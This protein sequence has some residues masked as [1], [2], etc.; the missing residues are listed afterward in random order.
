MA[1]KKNKK[2][3]K[4]KVLAIRYKIAQEN[5]TGSNHSC[6]SCGNSIVKTT[7]NKIFCSNGRTKGR[8]NCK[9]WF[10][11]IIDPN[12]RCRLTP[13][14]F[15]VILEEKTSY[16]DKFQEEYHGKF[17]GYTSE[18]YRIFGTTAIDEWDN[19]VYEVTGEDDPGDSMYWDAKDYS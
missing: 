15:N 3:R 17:R 5:T 12:K 13:Y 4:R 9:D 11:N 16:V 7:Y 8:G 18:G 10:W 1:K 2:T 14:F 6:P 19:P